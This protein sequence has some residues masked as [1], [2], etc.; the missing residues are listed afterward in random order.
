MCYPTDHLASV[1]RLWREPDETFVRG[2]FPLLLGREVDPPNLARFLRHLGRGMP[3]PEVLRHLAFSRE[4]AVRGLPLDWLA[5]L[6]RCAPR[7]TGAARGG[8]M[9]RARVLLTRFVWGLKRRLGTR[10]DERRA[11]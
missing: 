4:A 1:L 9:G 7:A 8:L 5:A 11:G 10:R 3:R 6:E 2:L